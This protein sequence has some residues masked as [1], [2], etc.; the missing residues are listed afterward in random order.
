MTE[1]TEALF[2]HT[3]G[4]PNHT[5]HGTFALL[6][7]HPNDLHFIP[8]FDCVSIEFIRGY[9]GSRQWCREA[10]DAGWQFSCCPSAGLLMEGV[11]IQ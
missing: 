8:I 5:A 3:N 6:Y 10:V 1:V 9:V 11:T 2:P 4:V 7:K